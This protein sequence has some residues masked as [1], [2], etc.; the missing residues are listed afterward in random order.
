MEFVPLLEYVEEEFFCLPYRIRK[1]KEYFLFV[2]KKTEDTKF[3][4]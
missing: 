3:S 2:D 1:K 4:F